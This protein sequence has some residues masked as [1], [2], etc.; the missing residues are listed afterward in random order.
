MAFDD[1]IEDLYDFRS[2]VLKIA[3]VESKGGQRLLMK[4][5]R[6]N[7][8]VTYFSGIDNEADMRDFLLL[9]FSADW[10]QQTLLR[11]TLREA[12][13]KQYQRYAALIELLVRD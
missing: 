4:L 1:C 8:W 12:C 7:L 3:E 6:Q 13:P 9:T 10:Q 2:Y 11:Q 5:A